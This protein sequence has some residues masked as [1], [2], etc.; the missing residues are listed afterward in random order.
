ML[1]LVGMVGMIVVLVALAAVL[2][3]RSRR[4][5]MRTIAGGWRSIRETRR[6][7][8]AA[9]IVKYLTKDYRWTLRNRRGQGT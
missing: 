9:D 4:A 7:L 8:H 2:D 5:G 3:R 1:L 6:D